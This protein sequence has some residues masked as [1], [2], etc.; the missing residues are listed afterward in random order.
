M[1]QYNIGPTL[2]ASLSMY[3]EHARQT[4]RTTRLID[5]LKEGD[6]VVCLNARESERIRRLIQERGLKGVE[7]VTNHPDEAGELLG[8]LPTPQGLTLFEHT[9]VEEYFR[10]ELEKASSRLREL[11]NALSGYG[12]PH[13]ITRRAA[14]EHARRDLFHPT[15]SK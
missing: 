5:S 6:R 10:R 15:R 13:R 3:T 7:M 12:E 14:E 9:W 1:D 8:R 2:Q 11:Q 4:G